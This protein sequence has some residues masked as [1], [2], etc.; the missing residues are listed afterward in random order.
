MSKLARLF[1]KQ[2]NKKKDSENGSLSPDDTASADMSISLPT[3]VKHEWHVG[4]KDGEFLGLPPAWAAW[5]Q[6]SNIR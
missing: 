2:P 3:N 6:G 1:S 4:H 5:L